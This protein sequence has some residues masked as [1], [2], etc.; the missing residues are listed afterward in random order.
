MVTRCLTERLGLTQCYKFGLCRRRN[1]LT[2]WHC[3]IFAL[4]TVAIFK[5]LQLLLA[6]TAI[7]LAH[8]PATAKPAAKQSAAGKDGLRQGATQQESNQSRRAALRQAIRS[9]AGPENASKPPSATTPQ[10][11]EQERAQLRDQ[12]RQQRI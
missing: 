2:I 5:S 1:G 6:V 10:L 4:S 12:L 9:Q 8:G 7:C 11:T 3:S